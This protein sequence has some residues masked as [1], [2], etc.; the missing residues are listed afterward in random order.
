VADDLAGGG[1]DG[2]GAG[3]GREPVAV[4]ESGDV[5]SSVH[6]FEPPCTNLLVA[7]E[8]VPLGSHKSRPGL[9]KRRG[10]VRVRVLQDCAAAPVELLGELLHLS[11]EQDRHELSS[12]D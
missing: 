11:I 5:L 2:C 10:V 12:L 3:P 9:R 8:D 7:E 6:V 4:G 1:F